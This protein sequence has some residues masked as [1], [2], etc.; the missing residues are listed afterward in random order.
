MLRRGKAPDFTLKDLDG[1][2]HSLS[3]YEGKNVVLYSGPHGAHP[4]KWKFLLEGT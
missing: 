2:N 1:K 4:A 3:D